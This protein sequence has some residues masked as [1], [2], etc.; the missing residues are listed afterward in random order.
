[1]QENRRTGNKFLGYV[2]YPSCR[3]TALYDAY[4][5]DLAH[6]RHT[7]ESRAVPPAAVHTQALSQELRKLIATTHPDQWH[8]HT[9]IEVAEAITKTLVSFR[10]RLQGG[11]L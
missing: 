2:S 4:L 3:F 11:K 5:Q 8:N 9:G 6:R 10:S 7:A 1:L